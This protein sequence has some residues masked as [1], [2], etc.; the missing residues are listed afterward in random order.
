VH[1]GKLPEPPEKKPAPVDKGEKPAQA[2]VGTIKALAADGKSFT[3]QPAPTEKDKEPAPIDIQIGEGAAITEGKGPGKLA[4]GQTVSDRPQKGSDNVA[5]E[6]HI[7]KLSEKPAKPPTPEDKKPEDKKGEDR[8][9]A[10][11]GTVKAL[12]DDGKSFTLQLPP[13]EK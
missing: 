3:L 9:P 13:T 1:I 12:S 5:R 6:V 7:G 4:V 8:K 10:L 11:V 2:L